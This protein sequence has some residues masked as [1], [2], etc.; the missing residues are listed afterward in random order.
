[1]AGTGDERLT[2][3]LAVLRPRERD[4]SRENGGGGI[5]RAKAWTSSSEVRE[6]LRTKA[7]VRLIWSVAAWA[8]RTSAAELQ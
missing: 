3:S 8:H 5:G 4:Q 1:M 7:G 2:N 6:T